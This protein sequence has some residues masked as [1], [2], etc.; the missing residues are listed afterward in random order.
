M[1]NNDIEYLEKAVNNEKNESLINLT[2]DIIN[3]KKIEILEK[4]S[5]SKK[6]TNVL[7]KK[8]DDYRYVDE[9]NELQYGNFLRWISLNDPEN[10]ILTK[11]GGVLCDI[12][13]ED[14]SIELVIKNPMN[15]FFQINM[16]EHLLFQK[17]SNQENIILYALDYLEK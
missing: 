10:L 12:K 13:I 7:L 8:L 2:F 9:I 6:E 5:L 16:G 3:K 1:N 14:N 11:V 15:R 17:L 4:L